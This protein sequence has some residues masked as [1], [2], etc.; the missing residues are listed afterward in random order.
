MPRVVCT[1]PNASHL[2][3]GVRFASLGED[4]GMLSEELSD[5]DAA[6]FLNIPGYE[7]HVMPS[8]P[9]AHHE[10]KGEP[11][12]SALSASPNKESV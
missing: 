10:P 9:R 8:E 12:R 3:N 7:P 4:G 5:A 2:I 11:K 1:L 6:A